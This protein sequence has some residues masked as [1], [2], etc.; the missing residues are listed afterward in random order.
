MPRSCLF[1][2][3]ALVSAALAQAAAPD[4]TNEPDR[5]TPAPITIHGLA[6][7]GPEAKGL[8]ARVG[9]KD[10]LVPLAFLDFIDVTT[11][12]YDPEARAIT[13]AYSGNEYVFT[14]ES[15]T[16]TRNG[17][18]VT[19]E[20]APALIGDTVMLPI[21]ALAD[22]FQAD[23]D[24]DEGV[25]ILM[26]T[27][28]PHP[29]LTWKGQLYRR[30]QPLEYSVQIATDEAFTA[31]VVSDKVALT[32]QYV[33]RRPLDPG[34]Y[35]WRVKPMTDSGTDAGWH[36]PQRLRIIRPA[37]EIAVSAGASPAEIHAR[38]QEAAR[39][40]P[41]IVTFEKAE[42]AGAASFDY[43]T[44][45]KNRGQWGGGINA[46]P[47]FELVGAK[48]LI[49]DGQGSR[50]VLEDDTSICKF[51]ACRNI[52]LRNASFTT[53]MP[54]KP[55][56]RVLAVDPARREFT[57]QIIDGFP[58]PDDKPHYYRAYHE[59]FGIFDDTGA[60][61]RNSPTRMRFQGTPRKESDR[62]YTFTFT[63]E[64]KNI[65]DLPVGAI[66][67]FVPKQSGA[68]GA[69]CLM[70]DYCDD[71]TFQNI[72]KFENGGYNFMVHYTDRLK[73][74]DVVEKPET[75]FGRNE[76]GLVL[77]GRVGAWLDGY[78]TYNSMDD[79]LQYSANVSTIVSKPASNQ[80]LLRQF[81]EIHGAHD[82]PPVNFEI[83][84]HWRFNDFRIGDELF[85]YTSQKQPTGRFK[86]RDLQANDNRTFLVTLDRDIPDD[87][88][89][90]VEKASFPNGLT[91]VVN[92]TGVQTGAAYRHCK[93]VNIGRNSIYGAASNFLIED[94][95][96][97]HI[98][99]DALRVADFALADYQNI[100]IRRN[101]IENGNLNRYSS[102]AVSVGTLMYDRAHSYFGSVS[103][104][105][106][107]DNEI[108]DANNSIFSFWAVDKVLVARNVIRNDRHT[109]FGRS[110]W[111]PYKNTVLI[112]RDSGAIAFEDNRLMD[113]REFATPPFAITNVE[114][115]VARRNASKNGQ[116][117]R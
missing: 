69:L 91:V 44:V 7:I 41:A 62:T 30:H 22:E 58:T 102:S 38:L 94:C 65:A 37:K 84:K 107:L 32:G 49:I 55:A 9:E 21:A 17:A 12:R 18:P 111:N 5:L 34:D 71:I 4:A 61:I 66:V 76:G 112:A 105:S 14:V 85:I 90:V 106:I 75:G 83:G 74:L 60:V 23:L 63:D 86:V 59:G 1:F 16:A 81:Q 110:D 96:F 54:L 68:Y 99:E 19:L 11:H 8:E 77:G 73:L 26:P 93:F 117:N 31:I 108:L 45:K 113:G 115:F 25:R 103:R 82:L 29:T 72:R 88:P 27:I 28:I 80:L 64:E 35:W 89:F 114:A 43:L 20:I 3:V 53:P 40:S 46:A 24:L 52:V 51:L 13:V 101:L 109:D 98:G 79:G 104:V 15:R 57:L 10:A 78:E 47:L 39:H 48:N 87:M 116:A 56:G 6:A 92:L 2:T 97:R 50:F 100:L 33:P 95:E 36:T 67:A 70:T 42:Y